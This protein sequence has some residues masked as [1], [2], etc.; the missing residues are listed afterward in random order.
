MRKELD[1]NYHPHLEE[2]IYQRWLEKNYFHAEPDGSR[3]PYT[4]MMPPAN[5][6]GQLH[7]GHALTFT[8]QDVL[9]RRKR[10]QG[11]NTLWLP[12][13]DHA[14]I[15]T[16]VKIVDSMIKEGLTKKDLG[17]EGFLARAWKW[18]EEYGGTIVRQ[19][20]SLGVSCDWDRE[21]FTMDEGLSRAVLSTFIHLYEKGWIYRGEKLINWC[22]HCRTTISDAEVEHE[23]RDALLYY[24]RYPIEDGGENEN[25]W[26]EFATTRPETMLGDTAVAVHAEDERYKRLIGKTV[27]VPFVNRSIPVIADEYVE[28]GFG[29]GVVKITPAHDPNDFAVGERHGLNRI[30][31]LN[32]DG[33]LNGAAG[34]FA[35]MTR[36]E[37]REKITRE[38]KR[39]G[40]FVKTEPLR[41][42]VG[43][44]DRCHE[45]IEPMIKLQWFVKME[46][47]AKPALEVY[48]SGRLRIFP[49]RFGKIYMRWLENIR[50]WCISRQLWWG[51]RIPA[52]YC[53][54]CG[55][56]VIALEAPQTCPG[57]GHGVFKQ[58][59]DTLD[60]W[61]SSA[62]WPFSTL[63]W[64]DKTKD[65]AYFYPTD[66]LVTGYE[67]LFFW[68]IRMIFSGLELMGEQ[69]FRDV[70]L[71]G[72]VRDEFGR[73]MSKSLGNGIDPL[74][75]IEQYG[76][77]A[78]RLMLLTGNALE[79]DTRFFEARLETS[80]NFINK[81]WN[82]TRFL[83]LHFDG[84]EPDENLSALTVMDKWILTKMNQLT[85]AAAERMDRYDLGMAAQMIYDFVWDELCDWYVEMI[86]PRLYDPANA[87]K[88]TA[89]W[90]LKTVLTTALKLLHPYI[91]F[92]TEEI[93]LS[94]QDR[95]ETILLSAWPVFQKKY[96]FPAEEKAVERMKDVVRKIRAARLDM[97]VPPA[98]KI[99]VILVSA[100]LDIRTF[101]TGARSAFALLAGAQAVVIQPDRSGVDAGAVSL[102]ADGAVAYLPLAE[103]V[104]FEKEIERLNREIKKLAVEMS[105]AQAKLSNEGFLQKAPP[106]LIAEEREKWNKYNTMLAKAEEQKNN[107]LLRA[108]C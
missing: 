86:K 76:A 10:M 107:I 14:A 41:H 19:L 80:R 23:E 53:Q 48:Q 52:Y 36:L 108:S 78:L 54:G 37:C 66:V 9:I 105:R 22:P 83:L 98:K 47:L 90:T 85:A 40:L 72:I 94:L 7:M 3:E 100:D 71:H 88:P 42:A 2:A 8:I 5:I 13:T 15:S 51:H 44:H 75:V 70:M 101:F 96:V 32:D 61:F 84:E 55:Q 91:P 50:D 29:S 99:R 28:M 57:C 1:K 102:V 92:V 64:P 95:E 31:I 45:I 26:I 104:D 73:K 27:T 103:L 17:R 6:T 77:D 106:E 16:E 11:Y 62:L 60:T 34:P 58:D 79:N 87:E 30:N 89:I 43:V 49:E 20:K 74:K 67:I 33:T 59:E 46:Q 97:N 35:G 21:R 12:G 65:L 38:M 81:V 56:T 24:F 18:K 39:L 68:V 69:P 82:A 25:A 63:G 93:F 4:I